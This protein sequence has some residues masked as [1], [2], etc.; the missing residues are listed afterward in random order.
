MLFIKPL[1]YF[2]KDNV[3]FL[4]GDLII[5][6]N[7]KCVMRDLQRGVYYE[8]KAAYITKDH[9]KIYSEIISCVVK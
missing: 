1:A 7:I 3:F 9:H 4:K 8:C 2:L 5:S 6:G